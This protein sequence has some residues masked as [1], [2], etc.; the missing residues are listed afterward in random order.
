M[1]VCVGLM[2][3]IS[4]DKLISDGLLVKLEAID[5][6]TSVTQK[7]TLCDTLYSIYISTRADREDRQVIAREIE[8]TRTEHESQQ[9]E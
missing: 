1:P 2:V 6:I 7:D 3:L 4:Y 8:K 9:T 5:G